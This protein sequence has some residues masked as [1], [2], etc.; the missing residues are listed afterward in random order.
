MSIVRFPCRYIAGV[1]P[2]VSGDQVKVELKM[3]EAQM[4]DALKSMLEHV[5]GETWAAWVAQINGE[6][7]T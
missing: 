4:L 1:D 6:V 3:T 5:P 2:M 7:V